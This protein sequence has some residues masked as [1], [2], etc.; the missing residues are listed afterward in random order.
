MRLRLGIL[1][2]LWQI[3]GLPCWYCCVGG[4]EGGIR[5]SAGHVQV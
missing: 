1:T 2:E 3:V 4:S 5:L